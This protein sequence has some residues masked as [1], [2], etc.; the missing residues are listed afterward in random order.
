MFA[1]VVSQIDALACLLKDAA[2]LWGNYCKIQENGRLQTLKSLQVKVQD[3][4][5]YVE[6][7]KS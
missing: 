5:K 7:I 6:V 4:G 2:E 3:R 1:R